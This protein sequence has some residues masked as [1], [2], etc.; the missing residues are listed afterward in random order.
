MRLTRPLIRENG[1]FREA[2]W[3]EALAY[4][5]RRLAEVRDK[6]GPDGIAFLFNIV[7]AFIIYRIVTKPVRT[8]GEVMRGLAQV[9]D[10]RKFQRFKRSS[11]ISARKREGDW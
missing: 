3:E 1:S 2:S 6:Y 7:C 5:G 9:F 11:G 8:L 10:H 4:A